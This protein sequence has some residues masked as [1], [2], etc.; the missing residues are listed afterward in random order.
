M[1]SLGIKKSQM[2]TAMFGAK[3]RVLPNARLNAC[4][5]D[6][7]VSPG[8]A[9]CAIHCHCKQCMRIMRI[10]KGQMDAGAK[11][12]QSSN[13]VKTMAARRGSKNEREGSNPQGMSLTKRLEAETAT[14]PKIQPRLQH[15]GKEKPLASANCSGCKLLCAS[16]FAQVALCN[17]LCASCSV[18]VDLRKRRCASS[19]AQEVALCKL[20]C[21]SCSAQVLFASALLASYSAQVALNLLASCS[22]H[23]LCASCSAQVARVAQVCSAQVAL[24][25]LLC[26]NLLC[27]SALRK[28]SAYCKLLCASCSAQGAVQ[29]ALRKMLCASCSVQVALRRVYSAYYFCAEKLRL[30][31]QSCGNALRV[32]L[33]YLKTAI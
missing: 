11:C 28:C 7:G 30:C 9:V 29:V 10:Q 1:R 4:E 12:M 8:T 6:D 2:P 18:Q 14:R 33:L 32:L 27:A 24:Q 13:A 20:L 17:L 31:S 5:S 19:S 16:C 21:V 15:R 23:V 25:E 26:A 22:A 3:K